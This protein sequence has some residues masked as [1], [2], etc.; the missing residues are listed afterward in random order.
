VRSAVFASQ[1]KLFFSIPLLFFS[2]STDNFSQTP[3]KLSTVLQYSR[4]ASA[5]V[6]FSRHTK[7]V[8]IDHSLS[9]LDRGLSRGGGARALPYCEGLAGRKVL[10]LAS[11]E[12]LNRTVSVVLFSPVKFAQ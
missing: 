12:S 11:I 3:Q 5:L 6:A 4:A 9:F 1:L 7:P 10:D 2:T 8:T